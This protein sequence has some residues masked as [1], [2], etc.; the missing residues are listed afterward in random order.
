MAST[1]DV[2]DIIAW[3]QKQGF[4]ITEK[5]KHYRVARDGFDQTGTVPKSPSDHRWYQNTRAQLEGMFDRLGADV[6]ATFPKIATPSNSSVR[7]SYKGGSVV[8]LLKD[9]TG[10]KGDQPFAGMLEVDRSGEVPVLTI[11]NPFYSLGSEDVLRSAQF[12]EVSLGLGNQKL[13]W[14]AVEALKDLGVDLELPTVDELQRAFLSF[15]REQR[16]LMIGEH[17]ARQAHGKLAGD[18]YVGRTTGRVAPEVPG[19]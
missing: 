18:A 12:I 5:G 9:L 3:L 4:R 19:R 13:E 17:E 6:W 16:T 8:G 2:S 1:K 10:A 11:R 7:D 14:P 15:A